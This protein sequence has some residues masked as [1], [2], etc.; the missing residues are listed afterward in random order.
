MPYQSGLSESLG[1]I[2]ETTV[3]T[4]AT[5]NAWYEILGQ[6]LHSDPTFLDSQSIQAG[7]AYQRGSQTVIS[8]H[9]VAGDITLEF[10]DKGFSAVGG[11]GMGFWMKHALG[12][13]AVPI[14]IGAT[15]AYRQSHVP[16]PRTGLSF[17]T[18]IGNP[19]GRA[20]GTIKPY[21][22][23][24]CKITSWEF[25][26]NDNQV[27]Q[28][29]FDVDGWKE[30]TATGLVTPAYAAAAYQS[31]PFT[32]AD[33]SVFTLG[34]TATTSAG[35]TS[36]ASGVSVTSIVK[37]VTITGST[38]M[39]DDGYG[40]GNSGV[41]S[42]QFENG[43]PTIT[44]TL[45]CE[46]TNQ[47]EIYSLFAANTNTV[48]ELDFLHGDA[49]TS[50]P[51][52]LSFILPQIKFKTGQVTMNGPDV[53]GMSVSFQAYQDGSTNPVIQVQLVSQDQAI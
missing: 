36:V 16:G 5:V 31:S 27:A 20:A 40:L 14:V 37:G 45:D 4:E 12:S 28:I 22:Y 23:R 24:G 38:P 1:V 18:Q 10:R 11:K 34:G 2:T 49:G 43:I 3:G 46:F 48:M 53:L 44:G 41:K 29:K 13:T 26:C 6:T 32:F 21:T 35:V 8:R 42:E 33:A 25:S 9:N 17:T 15:T 50:N 7:L 39:R 30:N 51:Y 19:E 52:R 47:A